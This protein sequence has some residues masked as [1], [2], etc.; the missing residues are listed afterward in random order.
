V[1]ERSLN[2]TIEKSL[3]LWTYP[4]KFPLSEKQWLQVR[5]ELNSQIIIDKKKIREFLKE[6][7][8]PLYFLD[9]ETFSTAIP[10]FDISRPY[11]QLVF[12]YS[13]HVL[14]SK[15][16]ELQHKEYLAEVNGIDPRMKFIEQLIVDCGKKGNILV[17]NI[18]FES[19]KLSELA[20]TFPRYGK[21]INEIIHRL[22]DLMIPFQKRWYYTPSMKGSYSIKKVLPALVPELS[23]YDL[24][25]QE[26]G[27]AINTFSAM[28]TGV[29][30]GDIEQTLNDLLAYC[31]LDTFAMVKILEKLLE[32]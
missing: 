13:L 12:Q 7:K 29:F 1:K 27:T 26:G 17:Y 19:G 18:S 20:N 21:E 16:S 4:E 22:K 30:Q 5:S 3:I 24:N 15:K 32:I 25:I 11:Q 6:L 8:Y 10:I 31:K 23:Y 14:Q 2:Y 9:F 28:L